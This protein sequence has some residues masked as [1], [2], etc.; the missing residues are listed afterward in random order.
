MALPHLFDKRDKIQ[1]FYY[2]IPDFRKN[3]RTF[4]ALFVICKNRHL[5]GMEETEKRY[6][7]RNSQGKPAVFAEQR[8][9]FLAKSEK[10]YCEFV[11]YDEKI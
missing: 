6:F 7:L 1:Q 5:F 10:C 2:I 3:P 9:F 4:F 8:V 11:K